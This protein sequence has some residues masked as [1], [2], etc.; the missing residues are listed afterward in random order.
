MLKG[1]DCGRNPRV[2]G[3]CDDADCKKCTAIKEAIRLFRHVHEHLFKNFLHR[4][5]GMEFRCGNKKGEVT[6]TFSNLWLPIELGDKLLEVEAEEEVLA[7][8]LEG[9]EEYLL[10]EQEGMD[11]RLKKHIERMIDKGKKEHLKLKKLKDE[12][13]LPVTKWHPESLLKEITHE[14]GECMLDGRV[15]RHGNIVVKIDPNVTNILE[16]EESPEE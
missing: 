9:V 4:A 15:D 8:Q 10:R 6:I 7:A 12:M 14:F 1:D 16:A 3:P 13:C 5:I 11:P 2:W